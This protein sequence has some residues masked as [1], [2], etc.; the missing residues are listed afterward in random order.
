[1]S[2]PEPRVSFPA[3]V[4]AG[5]VFTVK[6][7]ITHGMETGLRRDEA[8]NPIPRKI[9][10]RFVCRHDGAEVFSADFHESV[11]AN[12]FVEFRLRATRSGLLEFSWEE[13]GG[14]VYRLEHDLSVG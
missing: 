9:I 6:A 12:P 10:N 14:S 8:G 3:R 2:A 4:D 13:D 7:L 1:M 11:A 5:E